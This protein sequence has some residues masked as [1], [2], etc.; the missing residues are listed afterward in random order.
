MRNINFF[1][2]KCFYRHIFNVV[3]YLVIC[4]SDTGTCAAP[5]AHLDDEEITQEEIETQ[6]QARRFAADGTLGNKNKIVI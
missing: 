6:E 5:E 4:F 2:F 3:A 1:L